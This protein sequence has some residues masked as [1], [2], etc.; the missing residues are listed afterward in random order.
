MLVRHLD[1]RK[2]READWNGTPDGISTRQSSTGGT[3]MTD[4]NAN[5]GSVKSKQCSQCGEVKLLEHF[6]KKSASKDGYR[7]QCK[8]CRKRQYSSPQ[9]LERGRKYYKANFSRISELSKQR[10]EL[11][12]DGLNAARRARRSSDPV[13]REKVLTHSRDSKARRKQDGRLQ[14]ESKKYYEKNSDRI[15]E[16]NAAY[17]SARIQRD[18]EYKMRSR[19]R[20]RGYQ[21]IRGALAG[22]TFMTSGEFVRALGIPV[23]AFLHHLESLF[24]EHM[25]W[26]NWGSY[27]HLDHI[28]PLSEAKLKDRI[29]FLAVNNWRNLQPLEA[30]A[31][32]AKGDKVTTEAQELFDSLKEEFS[33][34]IA[35]HKK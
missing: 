35:T 24:D 11:N 20:T 7:S 33:E 31:N 16:N 17:A 14:A 23:D 29:E 4:S 2:M 27:W 13:H 6:H 28:Y 12:K 1:C 34:H 30:K 3:L 9:N 26:D 18:P 19:L 22:V 25:T 15:K 5:T 8:S 10:Y 21:V 32:I